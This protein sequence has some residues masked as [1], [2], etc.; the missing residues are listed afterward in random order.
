MR[1][2]KHPRAA[3][4]GLAIDDGGETEPIGTEGDGGTGE[5]IEG[6]ALIIAHTPIGE[7]GN[8]AARRGQKLN[9]VILTVSHTCGCPGNDGTVGRRPA[10]IVSWR[11]NGDGSGRRRLRKLKHP[12]PAINRLTVDCGFQTEV[13][14]AG[15][16]GGIGETAGLAAVI[17]GAEITPAGDTAV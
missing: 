6:G 12:R 14:G 9:Q 16:D 17:G 15:G 10:G 1:E 7:P 5:K 13:V 2:L 11:G 3:V 8:T 4:D